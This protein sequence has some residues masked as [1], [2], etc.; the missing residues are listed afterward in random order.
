MLP[1]LLTVIEQ[2]EGLRW[3]SGRSDSCE[4]PGPE[5]NLFSRR[6]IL[7]PPWEMSVKPLRFS[8]LAMRFAA[9]TA[10]LGVAGLAVTAPAQTPPAPA[11]TRTVVAGTKLTSL[12]NTPVYFRAVSVA[13]PASSPA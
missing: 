7:R 4:T 10:L 5:G 9:A 11:I 13:S 6:L 2:L 3:T 12:D 1:A 8:E